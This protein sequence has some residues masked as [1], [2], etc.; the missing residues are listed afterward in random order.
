MPSVVVDGKRLEVSSG[1]TALEALRLAGL[2]VPTACADP[3]LEPSGACRLC[4]V[5]LKGAQDLVSAC[6][7]HVTD[8]MEIEVDTFELQKTRR[9]ELAMLA[10]HYPLH[11]M[12]ELPEKPFH[13]WLR[14][15]GFQPMELLT[16]SNGRP[17]SKARAHPK[18]ES[19]PYFRFDP[20]ACIKCYACVRA[21]EELGGS[22][23]WQIFGR[24]SGSHVAPDSVSSIVDSACKSC[25]AC[26]DVCPTAALVD[27]T[28]LRRG[29]P[30]SWT[31]TTCP[32]CGVGCELLVGVREGRLVQV[33]PVVGSPV[34]KGHLCVK[35]RYA[36]QFVHSK[37]RVTTPMIRSNGIFEPVSWK[38][39]I[40]Y[41]GDSFR[42]ISSV[43]G[44]DS[45]G[46][47]GSARAPNEDN[48]LTQ[49]FARLVLGTNNV[50][51][52]ARVCH[53][54]TATALNAM[55]GTGAATNS[56]DDIE[57]ASTIMVAGCNP[58]ENHPVVGERIKQAVQ[59]GAKLI[60][61]DPRKTELARLA[62]VHVQLRPGT[63]IPL[64]NAMAH[65]IFEEGLEDAEFLS[66][67]ALE[68]QEY[69]A[70]I[71]AWTPERAATV[72][73]IDA[74]TVRAAARI[75][76][77]SRPSMCFHGLGVTEHLQGVEGVM[78]LVNLAL[79][80]GNIGRPGAGINPLRGQNNVQGAAHMG[81]EPDHLTGYV[82]IREAKDGFERAWE[83]PIP[84]RPGL[85]LMEML[86]EA[87]SGRFK[88]LWA[89]GYDPFLTN[90]SAVAGRKQFENLEFVV[91]QDLFMT[92]MA[93]EFGD[94]F[95][96][97]CSSF[98]REGTFMNA[99]RR[100]SKVNAAIEPIGDSRPDWEIIQMVAC[101][102]GCAEGF[103]FAGAK[104]IWNEIRAV[105]PAGAGL[106]YERL[107]HGGMQWP[108]PSEEHPGTT[109]LHGESFH[110]GPKAYLRRLEYTP[111][112]EQASAEYPFMLNTG[113]TLY[114]FNT[115]SMSGRTLNK[116]LRPSDT[117]DMHPADARALGLRGGSA[118]RMT[119]RYGTA[120][121]P[122]RLD[123]GIRKGELFATFH[124]PEIFLNQVTSPIRDRLVDTPEYK[125]TAVRVEPA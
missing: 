58:S 88:A 33:R 95:L 120:V 29:Q 66:A 81:C 97:A 113:R 38:E 96:P 1:S 98:E 87:S 18:D 36:H 107:E 73:G 110:L 67:R 121:L 11:Y 109:M 3:R 84:D 91:V 115:G 8:G 49:K 123:L 44:P 61:I 102:M 86:E 70:F 72:C 63:N 55:L 51:C 80:T 68:I 85:N 53:G 9:S 2:D 31:Q 34:S 56:F 105:W 119:S 106:A 42:R 22:S 43:H 13:K 69:K 46:V 75:Y 60:V 122:L 65:V 26:V 93:R 92:E 62:H 14:F 112:E 82:S 89:I 30:T 94:V 20:E 116:A 71:R 16:T 124:S 111:T 101:E 54:P 108:C 40:R 27:K 103:S 117:L 45:I 48:Y 24:A 77:R 118:V 17:G 79:V 99:E 23:V 7:L 125:V 5:K 114:Q 100:I 10:R 4:L 15:Y 90:P 76:A 83:A 12:K 35:G 50:D 41:V 52:C 28:R 104:E 19:N 47:L 59:H 64:L 6:A 57:R 74:E 78:T 21:C 32:Y 25:G 37:D 39:A